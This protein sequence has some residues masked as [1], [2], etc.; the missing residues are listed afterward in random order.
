MQTWLFVACGGAI[1]ACLRFGMTELMA[2]LLGRHFPYG[3]LTVNVL[4]SFIMGIAFALISNG[5]VL[6]HP[7]KP[8]LMVGILGAL[9]TF[10]SFALDTV[11]L[12]QQG[13]W[14]KAVL[15]MGLNLFLCLAMVV[16][17]MQLVGSRV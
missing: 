2:L 11:L 14:L 9:T 1:G 4:G 17:G 16:L 15:N 6:E 7:M 13:A 3:T 8:L 5:H 10:S 12:A